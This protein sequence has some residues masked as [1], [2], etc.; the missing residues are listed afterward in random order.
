MRRGSSR[1]PTEGSCA[2]ISETGHPA[3]KWGKGGSLETQRTSDENLHFQMKM[4]AGQVRGQTSFTLFTQEPQ[5]GRKHQ[6]DTLEIAI[7]MAVEGGASSAADGAQCARAADGEWREWQ[8]TEHR[9]SKEEWKDREILP[10]A[11]Q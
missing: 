11:H 10:Q 6:G 7:W 2:G 3:A 4:K 5:G 8:G 9:E 1:G